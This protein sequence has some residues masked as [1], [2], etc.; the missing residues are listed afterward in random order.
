MKD[1]VTITRHE[2][3]HICSDALNMMPDV[4]RPGFEFSKFLVFAG[5]IMSLMFNE[6]E[7]EQDDE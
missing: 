3:A 6:D 2:M 4:Q 5:L 7:E 1:T